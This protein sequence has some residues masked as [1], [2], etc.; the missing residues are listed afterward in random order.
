MWPFAVRKSSGYPAHSLSDPKKRSVDAHRHVC[1]L[2]HGEPQPGQEAAHS[3]ST[4][5]CINPKHLSW[6][7]RIENMADAIAAK[8]LRGGG[9]SR[10]RLFEAERTYIATCGKSLITLGAEFGMEPAYIGQVRRAE[11]A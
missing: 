9:R 10:Q 7:N 6:K 8:T 3:C 1:A 5:L 2:A 11:A 4:K